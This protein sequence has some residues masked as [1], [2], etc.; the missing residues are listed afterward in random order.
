MAPPPRQ[1]WHKPPHPGRDRRSNPS[2]RRANPTLQIGAETVNP[3][4]FQPPQRGTEIGVEKE[5]ETKREGRAEKEKEMKREK[6]LA[7]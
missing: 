6:N 4:R 7:K 2:P 5:K 1:D 3:S